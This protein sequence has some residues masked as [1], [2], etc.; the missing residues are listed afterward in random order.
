MPHYLTWEANIPIKNQPAAGIEIQVKLYSQKEAIAYL[1][2]IV[3]D[4]N[5]Y[6]LICDLE[7]HGLLLIT[8]D[9]SPEIKGLALE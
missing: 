1:I 6:K 9:L 2:S 4:F 3:L 7:K 5:K 8:R